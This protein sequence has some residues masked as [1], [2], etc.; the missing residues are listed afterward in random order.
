MLKHQY[1]RA[2]PL[3]RSKTELT[4]LVPTKSYFVNMEGIYYVNMEGIYYVL[5]K[6]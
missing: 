1:Y 6:S 3:K 2:S 4:H 5:I